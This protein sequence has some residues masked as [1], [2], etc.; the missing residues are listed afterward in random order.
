M[1]TYKNNNAYPVMW[2]STTWKPGE[3]KI[4]SEFL[5]SQI[6]LTKTDNAP[7]PPSPI[8]VSQTL[9]LE[10]ATP[11]T[12]EVPYSRRVKISVQTEG[13]GA[14]SI[15]IGGK[16]IPLTAMIGWASTELEWS[17]LGDLTLESAAGATV[18]LLI[19]RVA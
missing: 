18:Y 19:E 1:P 10:A 8:L 12:V 14:A 16:T 7:V 5:P 13:E 6:G 15:T 2:G 3:E 11:Q 17:T 9:T 4:T